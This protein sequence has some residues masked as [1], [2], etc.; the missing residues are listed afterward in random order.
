MAENLKLSVKDADAMESDSSGFILRIHK[1]LRS[2]SEQ[3]GVKENHRSQ[4][5]RYGYIGKTAT[6]QITTLKTEYEESLEFQNQ[7]KGPGARVFYGQLQHLG[8]TGLLDDPG[9]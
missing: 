5:K 6:K 9:T 8:P 3:G 1:S 7:R 4:K 2:P